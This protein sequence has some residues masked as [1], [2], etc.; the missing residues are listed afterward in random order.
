MK[1]YTAPKAAGE[2][3]LPVGKVVGGELIR[4]A[5]TLDLFQ[6]LD[7]FLKT[8]QARLRDVFDHFDSD[9]NGTLD[10][11]ELGRFLRRLMPEV[12][13]EDVRYFMTMLD[14]DGDGN[15]TYEELMEGIRACMTTGADKSQAAEIRNVLVTLKDYMKENQLTVAEAFRK[16][17]KHQRGNLV[18]CVWWRPGREP[19]TAARCAPLL[20]SRVH[21]ALR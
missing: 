5:E 7:I 12:G 9:G 6:A 21:V 13:G 3:P 4:P 15:L 11:N 2:Y 14:L 17:D 19:A 18:R 20:C 10:G 1:V 8:Y 16:F